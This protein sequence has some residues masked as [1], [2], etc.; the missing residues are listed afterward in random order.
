M[1]NC[2]LIHQSTGYRFIMIMYGQE[3]L[4]IHEQVVTYIAPGRIMTK[5][6][7]STPSLFGGQ[8]HLLPPN[9]P[10]SDQPTHQVVWLKSLPTEQG[11]PSQRLS[12]TWPLLTFQTQPTMSTAM[13]LSI[14][15]CGRHAWTKLHP[16]RN[17]G[18]GWKELT[19]VHL[20]LLR[21]SVLAMSLTID[22][23]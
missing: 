23:K 14:L 22:S 5:L 1:D 3:A 11:F 2:I 13:Y 12:V 19:R 10:G 21:S 20:Q 9:D 16:A 7:P 15:N 8:R 18:L 17:W 6:L 4:V